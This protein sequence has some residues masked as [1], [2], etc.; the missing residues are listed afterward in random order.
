MDIMCL[1]APLCTDD[2]T[3]KRYV[4]MHMGI[5]CMIF[6]CKQQTAGG[7]LRRLNDSL[8]DNTFPSECRI[9]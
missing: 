2:H 6:A 5:M 1:V 7:M 3:L 4:F 8:A 9:E